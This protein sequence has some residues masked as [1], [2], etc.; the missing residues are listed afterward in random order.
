MF[1]HD[2]KTYAFTNQWGG[3]RIDA[4]DN[5]INAF[6]DAKVPYHATDAEWVLTMSANASIRR[7]RALPLRQLCHDQLRA[8]ICGDD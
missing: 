8:P 2:G 4:I 6:P 7:L 1:Y 5:I 3:R